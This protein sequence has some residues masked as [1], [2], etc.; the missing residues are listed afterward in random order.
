MQVQMIH[1]L[2]AIPTSVDHHAKAARR[3]LLTN[4]SRTMQ[5]VPQHSGIIVFNVRQ[6][7][8]LA[9]RNDENVHG[10]SRIDVME[11]EAKVILK[12]LLARN[13][14]SKDAAKNSGRWHKQKCTAARIRRS[15]TAP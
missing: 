8:K 11:G 12:N 15:G 10:S 7:S 14:T 9:F 3:V 5:Q 13:F 4:L 1:S 2:P 6:R